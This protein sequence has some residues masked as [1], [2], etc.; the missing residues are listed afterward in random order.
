M[1]ACI[2]LKSLIFSELKLT[3]FEGFNLARYSHYS[4]T[5]ETLVYGDLLCESKRERIILSRHWA[6][7]CGEGTICAGFLPVELPR[8][9]HLLQ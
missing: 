5:H 8:P 1:V 6:E 7:T 4:S 2:K 9:G 3:K